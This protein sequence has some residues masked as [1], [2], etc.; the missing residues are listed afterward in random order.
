MAEADSTKEPAYNSPAGGWGA[1]ASSA[2]VVAR[3]KAI[4]TAIP[5]LLRVNQQQG[6]DCPG[7]AWPDPKGERSAFEFCENGVKAVAWEATTK[8][9]DAA[10][11]S[12][13][14]VRSLQQQT[15]H[16]LES[17]GRLTEPVVYHAADDRFH[18]L[19]W[20]EAFDRIG[21]KLR[22]LADPR[23]ALFYTSGRT[24]NEAAFMYQLLAR[25]YGT[26]NLP[27][28]SNMC[29]E[30]SGVGLG[31]SIG[32]G[33]G[34]VSLADFDQAD[35]IFVIGQNPGTNHPRMLSA[36]QNAA[37]RGAKIISINPL[38]ERGL[39]EF[40]HPQHVGAMLCGKS[41]RISSLYLQPLIGGDMALLIGLCKLV[42][43]A[44]EQAPGTVLDQAFMDEHTL[45][46]AAFAEQVR[47]ADWKLLETESGLTRAEIAQ[48][49]DI[50][51]QAKSVICCWA[52]GLT[53]QAHGVATIQY[54]V[55]LLLMRGHIGRPGAGVC[56]V[57]GHSNVQGNRTVGINHNLP[58]ALG[59]ALQAKF[60]F[61]PPQEGGLD[62]VEA[63]H[64]MH[65]GEATF[66]MALGGNLVPASPDTT[67]T[68]EALERVEMAVH[69]AT[70]L[71]RTHL[72]HGGEAIILPCLG[73]TEK[74]LQASGP[75][76]VTVEDSMGEVHASSGT[77]EPASEQ[78]RS[79]PAIVAG[80]ATATLPNPGSYWQSW[81]E[82]YATVREAIAEVLPI[83][84]DYNTK[85]QNADG[86][87]LYNSARERAWDTASG[88]A[89]F[90]AAE[91]PRLGLPD[92]QLRLMTLRSH[93]QYNTTIYGNDDRYRGIRGERYVL[94]LNAEDLAERGLRDGDVLELQSHAADGGTRS[95][96]GFRAVA[97]NIPK[98]CAAAYFPEANVL[99]P[100]CHVAAGSNTPVSKFIPLTVRKAES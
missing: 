31:Q 80:I 49:A 91:L 54:V 17:Q 13:H 34:T 4:R 98:S 93:D 24:S 15:D 85:I 81:V 61:D 7:C 16:W 47:G 43:E 99:V 8:R 10:F 5:A 40:L 35:A 94:F 30:S 18:P 74:D 96:S 66:F 45:G 52:M 19:S 14:T 25:M 1:L 65:K 6:F 41:T 89:H 71:N 26:N 38:V 36:L 88:K 53:Q 70:K 48:A 22:G 28:C 64:A 29:H 92:G 84:A 20:D 2:R 60:S 57:R 67:Y 68:T 79:E 100:I 95:A 83:F 50:Y 90:T 69:V 21:A 59:S 78:L 27:D 62:V 73:R 51:L 87:S 44:E 32:I 82:D 46:F 56:P 23:Q 63:I 33:K 77:N 9:V 12:K 3:E 55:N 58:H 42:L 72:H 97:Y 39:E 86:F 37:K 76:V 75:Q 11:F